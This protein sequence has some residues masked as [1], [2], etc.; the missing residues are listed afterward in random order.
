MD[1]QEITAMSGVG[2]CG[3][4]QL[5][6]APFARQVVERAVV[7]HRDCYEAWYFSRHGRR[8]TLVAGRTGDPHRYRLGTAWARTDPR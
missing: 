6:V 3:R 8:P 2:V 1:D 7:Y 4:C 5:T